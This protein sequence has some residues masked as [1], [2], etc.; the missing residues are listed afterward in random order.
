MNFIDDG[1]LQSARLDF[2]VIS[3]PLATQFSHDKK[4]WKGIETAGNCAATL[5]RDDLL[6]H[7]YATR[8]EISRIICCAAGLGKKKSAKKLKKSPS[9]NPILRDGFR[10]V[11][12]HLSWNRSSN[13]FPCRFYVASRSLRIQLINLNQTVINVF[14]FVFGELALAWKVWIE[15]DNMFFGFDS[16]A[17]DVKIV[18]GPF[19]CFIKWYRS[20]GREWNISCPRTFFFSF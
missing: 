4:K 3:S 2:K 17:N 16:D 8:N 20:P 6:F 10:I 9:N 5:Q 12:L 14:L 18:S 7:F 1:S 13:W 19:K 15:H 11:V